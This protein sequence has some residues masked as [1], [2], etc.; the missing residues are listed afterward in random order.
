MKKWLTPAAAGLCA[1]A[2]VTAAYALI[3]G[4]ESAFS[5]WMTGILAVS[6]GLI[7]LVIQKTKGQEQSRP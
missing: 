6:C 5:R 4:E 2:A 3:F 7:V 1:A